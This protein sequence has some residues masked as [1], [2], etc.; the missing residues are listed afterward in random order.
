MI[1]TGDNQLRRTSRGY[2]GLLTISIAAASKSSRDDCHGKTG[3]HAP[4]DA[5]YHGTDQTC[6]DGWFAAHHIGSSSPHNGSDALR[7]REDSGCNASPLRD[8]LPA[9]AEALDHF[10]LAGHVSNVTQILRIRGLI[11]R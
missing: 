9:D 8:V 1:P 7:E 2:A 6:Q 4:Y 5:R 3:R 10:R 11:T